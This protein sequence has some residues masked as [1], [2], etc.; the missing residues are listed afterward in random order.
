LSYVSRHFFRRRGYKL[1][2][3]GFG[4]PTNILVQAIRKLKFSR[5]PALHSLPRLLPMLGDSLVAY[6]DVS[7][8]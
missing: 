7:N 2:T 5:E 8:N 6:K 4:N 1:L 3:V